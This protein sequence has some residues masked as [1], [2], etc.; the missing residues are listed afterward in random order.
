MEKE[1][2]KGMWKKG[3]KE[4]KVLNVISKFCLI[5]ILYMFNVYYT[6]TDN[7]E[8]LYCIVLMNRLQWSR[9]IHHH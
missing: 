5:F 6:G 7:T 4:I 3:G 8:V 9:S 1:R 2:G